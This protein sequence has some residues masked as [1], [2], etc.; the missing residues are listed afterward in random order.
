MTCYGATSARSLAS[1]KMTSN[2]WNQYNCT[3][4]NKKTRYV[5]GVR[6]GQ[7][8]ELPRFR[9][10]KL[11]WLIQE[12]NGS[13]GM[14]HVSWNKCNNLYEWNN[15]VNET[16]E[17]MKHLR[18]NETLNAMY[19]QYNMNQWVCEQANETIYEIYET[20]KKTLQLWAEYCNCGQW[21]NGMLI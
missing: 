6:T 5:K 21:K 9:E 16:I 15:Q 17:Q 20:I 18:V 13:N 2:R 4:F 19:N 11:C 1:G 8:C 7:E 3:L 12:W 10:H 14:K